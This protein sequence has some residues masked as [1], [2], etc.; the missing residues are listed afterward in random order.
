M[1]PDEPLA[2]E[3]LRVGRVSS[4]RAS[5]AADW[6][7]TYLLQVVLIDVCCGLSAGLLAYRVRFA[8][9]ASGDAAYIWFGLAMPFLWIMALELAGAYDA[10]FIGIGSDEFRRVINAGVCLT[11]V[12]AF[13][14][15]ATKTD[16][17]RGYVLVALPFITASDLLL[18]Y[19]RRKRLHESRTK[20]RCMGKAVIVGHSD[21]VCEL[22]A[23]LRRDTYH[24]L[25]VVA[26]CI[27]GPEQSA[28]IEGVPVIGGIESA[29]DIVG[30]V[31]FHEADTVAVL[32]CPEMIGPKLR[33][34]AWAL[35]KTGTDLCVAPALLESA[36]NHLP[37]RN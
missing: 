9:A 6:M 19:A 11:A 17:A 10:R 28:A 7:A 2:R 13:V 24:G 34:L 27:V 20:G 25:A 12:V 18:R 5:K 26:A 35:E 1:R 37:S 31:R 30:V 3:Q 8:T 33:E 15:Y 4:L 36:V 23:V 32:A 22:A 21:V 16:I 14:A 29:E